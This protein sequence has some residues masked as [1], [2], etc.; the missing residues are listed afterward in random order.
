MKVWKKL[1]ATSLAALLSVSFA[2]CAPQETPP[3]AQEQA[4]A[5]VATMTKA[6]DEAKSVTVA[7]SLQGN[8]VETAYTE[9]GEIVE[10]DGSETIANISMEVTFTETAQGALAM[11]MKGS[12]ASEHMDYDYEENADGVVVRVPDKETNDMYVEMFYFDG[13]LYEYRYEID[14]SM[15]ADEAA[16]IKANTKWTQ[17]TE[18]EDVQAFVVL[19]QVWTHAKQLLDVKEI[20]DVKDA[21]AEFATE[22]VAEKIESGEFAN[23]KAEVATDVVKTIEFVYDYIDAIDETKD[24]LRKVINDVLKT[25]D[26]VLTAEIVLQ[27]VVKY[28]KM[29]VAEALT[30]IDAEL[31]KNGTSLQ[32][33][34]DQVLNSEF[35]GVLLKDVIG[36]TEE[37]ITAAKTF[38]IASLKEGETGKMLVDD[39]VYQLAQQFGLVEPPVED[40]TETVEE[41]AE[42]TTEEET[43]KVWFVESLIAQVNAMLDTTLAELGMT[44]PETETLPEFKTFAVANGVQ[45]NEE[46]AAFEK[47][48]TDVTLNIISPNYE[49]VDGEEEGPTYLAGVQDLQIALNVSVTVSPETAVFDIPTDEEI[50]DGVLGSSSYDSVLQIEA[51]TF[52]GEIYYEVY[53]ENGGIYWVDG[54]YFGGMEYGKPVEI[55]VTGVGGWLGANLTIDENVI[56]AYY[57]GNEVVITVTV[58]EDGLYTVEGIPTE[59]EMQAWYDAQQAV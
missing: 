16:W 8:E 2:A 11:H 39:L 30:A 13:A 55:K 33:I 41:G 18:M 6:I 4:N 52:G 50:F 59:A 19:S 51:K 25:V 24:T 21:L 48:Y 15:T 14:D 10:E 58:T 37:E 46:T 57:E 53:N 17:T 43:E 32:L 49:E 27:E 3:T 5:Y 31:A 7:L 28:S 35:A 38:Q 23:G 9:A 29:T 20:K 44:L 26:P 22:F 36:M 47:L 54:N 42:G 45:F 40:G 1:T 34:K 12:M 56:V